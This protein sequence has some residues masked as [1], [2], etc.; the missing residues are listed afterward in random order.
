MTNE[1]KEEIGLNAIKRK[2]KT[3]RPENIVPENSEALNNT[4]DS[5]KILEQSKKRLTTKDL[6]K[7]IRMPLDTHTAIS[8]IATIED[9][10][11]Y[12]TLNKIVEFYINN[13]NPANKKIVKNSVKAVQNIYKDNDS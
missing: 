12:E 10:K 5:G 3:Q 9:K 7:S 4:T 11:I 1:K 13:M 6:P 8:T 2:N